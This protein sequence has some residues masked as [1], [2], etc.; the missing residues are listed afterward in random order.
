MIPPCGAHPH[1][2]VT[3]RSEFELNDKGELVSI[4][5]IWR[6]DFFFSA[7]LIAETANE[8]QQPLPRALELEARRMVGNL[9]PYQYF[10]ALSVN[11]HDFRLPVPDRYA[12]QVVR[13]GEQDFLEL[14]MHF[15]PEQRPMFAG[16]DVRWSVYDPTYYIAY[17]HEH[18]D[19]V[20]IRHSPA[21]RCNTQLKLPKLSEELIAYAF[22]LDQ[23][24]RDTDGLGLAFAEKILMR[25]E[26]PKKQP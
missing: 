19:N 12:L 2:W 1:N 21:L 10:S 8:W 6:F 18:A 22:S 16:K 24:Q 15:R 11:E 14:T 3:V 17:S 25:C 26:I 23:N 5:Q 20:T 9:E 7:M 4:T 13:S